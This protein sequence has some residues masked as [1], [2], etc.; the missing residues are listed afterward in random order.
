MHVLLEAAVVLPPGAPWWAG[1][2]AALAASPGLASLAAAWF[3]ARAKKAE[4]AKDAALEAR[5]KFLED[6]EPANVADARTTATKALAEARAAAEVAQRAAAELN[7][8]LED[9]QRRRDAARE[10]GQKRDEKIAEKVERLGEKVT[11]LAAQT[12]LLLDGKV[13]TGGGSRR[14]R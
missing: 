14:G 2:L 12:E 4:P 11:T 10:I 13:D 3:Q 6:N 1:A 9:E 5:V 7:R 8:H